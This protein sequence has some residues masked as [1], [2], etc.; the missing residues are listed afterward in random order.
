M[1]RGGRTSA[2]QPASEICIWQQALPPSLPLFLCG[3]Q[4]L[5]PFFCGLT[6]ESSC[7]RVRSPCVAAW[8]AHST[9]NAAGSRST[10]YSATAD[11][12]QRPRCGPARPSWCRCLPRPP[13]PQQ[14]SVGS[15]IEAAASPADADAGVIF[16]LP[17]YIYTYTYT[18]IHTLDGRHRGAPW[19]CFCSG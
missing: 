10:R 18:F 14:Q 7:C 15:G 13:R 19:G 5:P 3:Q 17:L 8:N 12:V 2:S 11:G 16:Q 6:I 4:A 1:P 9:G